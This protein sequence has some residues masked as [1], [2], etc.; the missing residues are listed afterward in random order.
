MERILRPG[1]TMLDIGAHH[2]FFTLLGSRKVGG[3]GRVLAFEPSPRERRKLLRHLRLNRCTNVQ[4]E[5]CALGSAPGEMDLFVVMGSE[6]GCNSLRPPNTPQPT[7]RVRVP[8]LTLETSLERVKMPQVDFIK[9]DVEGGE[10]DV[11]KGADGLLARRP[12]PFLLSEVQEI[13][14]EPWGYAAREIIEFLRARGYWWFALQ[15]DG[16]LMP[17][18]ADQTKFDGNFV[19]VPNERMPEM[20]LLSGSSLVV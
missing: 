13:R 3:G 12:R 11:L 8:V 2:G 10:L 6:T 17:V 1:M 4:V 20:A 14:T 7:K 15:T 16:S 5:A 9:L 18:P 19:A